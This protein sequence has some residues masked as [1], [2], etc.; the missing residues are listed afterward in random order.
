MLSPFYFRTLLPKQ[1][2]INFELPTSLSKWNEFYESTPVMD[3]VDVWD[4]TKTLKLFE[5]DD[6]IL[7]SNGVFV[8]KLTDVFC[9]PGAVY[10]DWYAKLLLNYE[11]EPAQTISLFNDKSK[12][13]L[14]YVTEDTYQLYYN[15][16]IIDKKLIHKASKG[17]VIPKYIFDSLKPIAVKL[18]IETHEVLEVKEALPHELLYAIK[19]TGTVNDHIVVFLGAIGKQ[20]DWKPNLALYPIYSLY[21][22]DMKYLGQSLFDCYLEPD[23]DKMKVVSWF[24]VDG[25]EKLDYHTNL[26]IEY[27]YNYDFDDYFKFTT[28][29]D[30]YF[31]DVYDITSNALSWLFPI[32]K[33]SNSRALSS[34]DYECCFVKRSDFPYTQ[35]TISPR[36]VMNFTRD[37]DKVGIS[38]QKD[39]ILY[40]TFDMMDISNMLYSIFPDATPGQLDDMLN[41]ELSLDFIRSQ[42][43][44]SLL[45]PD[46]LYPTNDEESIKLL[47][48]SAYITKSL[49]NILNETDYTST[50]GTIQNYKSYYSFETLIALNTVPYH[51][52]NSQQTTS[53]RDSSAIT[54][55]MDIWKEL[56]FIDIQSYV[57]HPVFVDSIKSAQ[58]TM[59]T[60]SS[61]Q[62]LSEI[63]DQSLLSRAQPKMVL[64]SSEQ[65]Y[66][67]QEDT[68]FVSTPLD[69]TSLAKIS[70]K[71]KVPSY[72][73]ALR[74]QNGNRQ[75]NII[76]DK[77]N[78]QIVPIHA[79]QPNTFY[80]DYDGL[81]FLKTAMDG[82]VLELSKIM[83]H[84]DDTR[85][86]WKLEFKLHQMD[87]QLTQRL[88]R[89]DFHGGKTV[90][91]PVNLL[92]EYGLGFELV[93]SENLTDADILKL[94]YIVIDKSVDE[95]NL[96]LERL[97]K[98]LDQLKLHFKKLTSE[99]IALR[100]V[101]GNRELQEIIASKD[102]TI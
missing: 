39:T 94:L 49:E 82:D 100:F 74:N 40:Y 77:T 79:D 93:S 5:N 45:L 16:L 64:D 71:N 25:T 1:S 36:Q 101:I 68:G 78:F 97:L 31:K 9:S 18:N 72:L 55:I 86:Q 58:V 14:K 28:V 30:T 33:M 61:G 32:C 54:Y 23:S 24:A 98:N 27:L 3:N 48:T 6:F 52:T 66:G 57:F 53:Q 95:K 69:N 37:G 65:C 70:W 87:N 76:A 96:Y 99:D 73:F 7:Y 4:F 43:P 85:N 90:S 34:K 12:Q 46:T 51:Y 35:H 8:N 42:K 102:A 81:L 47:V 89:F 19:N 59:E 26:A 22:G 60:W 84:R 92:Y 2:Y 38:Y 62:N 56:G 15:Q 80:V 29:V 20:D 50:D 91:I 21:F 75:L 41:V 17:S 67:L 11:Q 63:E 83:I 44:V 10:L 13:M 88:I